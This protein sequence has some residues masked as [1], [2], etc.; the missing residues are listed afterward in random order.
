MVD[1]CLQ[2]GSI[3]ILEDGAVL[4]ECCPSSHDSPLNLLVWIFV[5][6]A[7]SLFH[8]DSLSEWCLHMLFSVIIFVFDFSS[9]NPDFCFHLLSSPAI[10]VVHVCTFLYLRICHL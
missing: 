9:S 1:F 3:V 6:G 7:V 5:S 10:V 2:A 4:G 8:V